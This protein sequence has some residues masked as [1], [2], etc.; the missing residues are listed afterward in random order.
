MQAIRDDGDTTRA[1]SARETKF[2]WVNSTR[3]GWLVATALITRKPNRVLDADLA[4]VDW[5]FRTVG[6]LR[7][8]M[9]V[10]PRKARN[11]RS[12]SASACPIP[13]GEP[14]C[15]RTNDRPICG[16]ITREAKP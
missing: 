1:A 7:L 6:A 16:Q 13:P 5:E 3:L 8:T 14:W 10:W 12:N 9:V 4:D 11:A 2:R 15:T